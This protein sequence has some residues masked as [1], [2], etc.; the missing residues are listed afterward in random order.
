MYGSKLSIRRWKEGLRLMSYEKGDVSSC[1]KQTDP[2]K[3]SRPDSTELFLHE[4]MF[5]VNK[6]QKLP[7]L[8]REQNTNAK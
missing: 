4:T 3:F 6:G 1:I 2:P 8:R 5:H 7:E